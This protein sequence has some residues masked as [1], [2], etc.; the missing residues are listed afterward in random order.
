MKKR[1]F[2]KLAPRA[3]TMLQ[4]AKTQARPMMPM[5]PAMPLGTPAPGV[6]AMPGVNNFRR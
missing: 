6:P 5:Q 1:G 2:A 3:K 4:G